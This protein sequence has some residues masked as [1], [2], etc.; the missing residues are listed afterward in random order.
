MKKTFKALFAAVALSLAWGGFVSCSNDDGDGGSGPDAKKLTVQLAATAA[1]IEATGETTLTATTNSNGTVAYTW[2]L[3]GDTDSVTFDTAATTNTNK[4]TGK[5]TTDAV[6]KVTVKVVAK[7]GSETAEAT[8]E[9]TIK[10]KAANVPFAT[11]SGITIPEGATILYKAEDAANS[12]FND[13]ENQTWWN[14]DGKLAF[15]IGGVKFGN[16]DVMKITTQQG[17]CG[18]F[19]FDSAAKAIKIAAGQKLM[20]SVYTAN[21]LQFKPVAPDAEKAVAGKAEWQ[22][23]ECAYD[24]ESTFKQLGFVGNRDVTDVIEHYIDAVYITPAAAPAP[25]P[26]GKTPITFE[27]TATGS[28]IN[29]ELAKLDKKA[30]LTAGTYDGVTFAADAAI[31]SNE[32]TLRVE[33]NK[34]KSLSFD[35][36]AGAKIS[37]TVGSTSK[38]NVSDFTVTGAGLNVTD[39]S[40]TGTSYDAPFNYTATEDGTVTLT[41]G[42][43]RGIR[44]LKITVTYE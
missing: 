28:A 31:R 1:E 15:E 37:F 41:N 34:S 18:G 40:I 26:S 30:A 5:N 12:F 2:S 11:L 39:G 7:A 3:T 21:G 23:F 44:V 4:L 32:D 16:A 22:L 33:L 9:I 8:K 35:V 29:T 14:D 42:S 25:A 24:A 36:V 38:S 19:G 20:I 13:A 10:A 6:K 27:T 17:S 43:T